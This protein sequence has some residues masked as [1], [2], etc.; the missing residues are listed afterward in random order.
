[1]ERERLIVV[2]GSDA[3]VMAAIWAKNTD[4]SLVVDMVVK[5]EFVN[6]SVC[7][8]PFFLG[9]EVPSWEHL[10]HRTL[11]EIEALGINVHLNT[12]ALAIDASGKRLL[13]RCADR[14]E[15]MPYDRLVLAQ[16]ATANIPPLPGL[17]LDGVFTLHDM[18]DTL[19]IDRYITEHQPRRAVIV[20]AGYIGLEM[21][22]ALSRRRLDVTVVEQLPQ[23]LPTVDPELASLLAASMEQHQVRV[24][25]GTGIQAIESSGRGLS[26][27]CEGGERLAADMVMVVVGV[28]PNS[29]LASTAGIEITR[30]AVAVNHRM[31]TSCQDIWAAGDGVTTFHLLLGSSYL[32]LG[33]TAHK[34]GRVAGINAAGGHASFRGVVGTQVVKLFDHVVGRTGLKEEEARRAKFSPLTVQSEVMDH[35]AYY[36]GS[37][38]LRVRI[39]GDAVTGRLLGAQILGSY[40]AEVAKRVDLFALGLMHSVFVDDLNDWDL[41]YTPPVSSPFDPVQ[42]AAQAWTAAWKAR[43]G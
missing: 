11:S 40:G 27:S 5:D 25:T 3:G 28:R 22:E 17:D 14:E 20:G 1:M 34:Q 33:T 16:G 21:V 10:A 42:M 18:A 39:T 4:P 9:G 30:G 37:S 6:Y 24:L 12:E 15:E 43:Q 2:G 23:V 7:G 8:A 38:P 19:K 29:S 13:G 32:P 36:P 31:E 35:K 26:V 41:S